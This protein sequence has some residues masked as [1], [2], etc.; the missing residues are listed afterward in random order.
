MPA[1]NEKKDHL[2]IL[3]VGPA[4]VIA[5]TVLTVACITLSKLGFLPYLRIR[6]MVGVMHAVG[7]AFLVVGIWLWVSA[8]I[9]E[10]LREKIISNQLVTTG[11]YALVRNPIYSAF[12]F[13]MS[14]AALLSSNLYLLPLPLVFWAL[15]TVMMQATEEKWLLEQFGD[16]Y[17]EYCKRANRCI[18]WF[19]RH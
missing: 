13:V 9:K 19:P 17:K 7:T 4:Y 6:A 11:V 1:E 10:K 12:A 2:P 5:I 18:P 15:L 16:E 3:G 8:A 14:G